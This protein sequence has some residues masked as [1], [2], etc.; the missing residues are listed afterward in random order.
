MEPYLLRGAATTI[1]LL[2]LRDHPSY[3]YQLVQEIKRRSKEH[4]DFSEGTI[5]PLLY[6]LEDDGAIKGEWGPGSGDRKRKVYRLTSK[7]RKDLARRLA[8]W[9]TFEKGMRLALRNA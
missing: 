3:G 8:A 6:S 5:Y 2:I 4:L 9:E 7:G 1:L